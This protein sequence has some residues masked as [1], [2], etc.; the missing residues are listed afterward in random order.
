[1]QLMEERLYTPQE[2]AEYLRVDPGTVYRWLRS[3][4]L[5]AIKF[6]REYRITESQLKNFLEEH[7]TKRS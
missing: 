7:R 6:S 5:E 3:G 4:E 2:I 1:M